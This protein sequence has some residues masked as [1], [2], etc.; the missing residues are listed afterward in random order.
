M[1]MDFASQPRFFRQG[2]RPLTRALV[3]GALS[4]GLMIADARFQLLENT[5]ES[6][7]VALY[8]LQWMINA[9]LAAGLRLAEFVTAQAELERDNHALRNQ[10]ITLAARLQRLSALESENAELR[11]LAGLREVQ[12]GSPR[13]VEILSLSRDPFSRQLVIDQGTQAGIIAGQPVID[14][15]GLLG[16]VTRVAPLTSEVTLITEK[17]T[18]V[19][20]QVARNG[21]RGLLY[22][23]GNRVELRYLPLNADVKEGDMLVTSGLGGVFPAGL[24]VARVSLVERDAGRTFATIQSEPV[25]LVDRGRFAL[26]LPRAER[27]PQPSP[28]PAPLPPRPADEKPAG[29]AAH[30]NAQSAATAAPATGKPAPAATPSPAVTTATPPARSGAAGSPAPVRPATAT[31]PAASTAPAAPSTPAAAPARA[32]T[33]P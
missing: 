9:P 29:K 18:I 6:A 14:A 13:F 31:P 12:G 22:G 2:P 7:A 15:H 11:Q 23:D 25:G 28:H 5:R 8:P 21:I 27:E 33:Q 20:I 32:T 3:C 1:C 24:N 4:L 10:Q 16:Q 26:V 17:G 30:R 19:P